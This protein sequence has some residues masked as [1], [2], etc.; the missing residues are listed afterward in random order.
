MGTRRYLLRPHHRPFHGR[1]TCQR[2]AA[3]KV[4]DVFWAWERGWISL[5]AGRQRGGGGSG[6]LPWEGEGS[7][8]LPREGEGSGDP[9]AVSLSLW[10]PP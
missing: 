8:V 9:C 6:V 1:M 10:S 2:G 7:G 3:P 5:R 4:V